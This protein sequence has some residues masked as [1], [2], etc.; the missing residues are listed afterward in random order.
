MK[1]TSKKALLNISLVGRVPEQEGY[2]SGI[3]L[4]VSLFYSACIS[5]IIYPPWH[6]TAKGSVLTISNGEHVARGRRLCSTTSRSPFQPQLF[7]DPVHTSSLSFPSWFIWTELGETPAQRSSATPCWWDT[8]HLWS[9]TQSRLSMEE[10]WLLWLTTKSR[11]PLLL[12]LLVFSLLLQQED[13]I[14]PTTKA[15]CL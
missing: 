13:K 11:R 12:L 1:C 8:G 6:I 14:P 9:R 5:C 3:F 7:Y 15:L 4:K 2:M 10:G